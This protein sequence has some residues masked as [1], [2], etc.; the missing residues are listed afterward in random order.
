M[1]SAA[2]VA[3]TW[4]HWLVDSWSNHDVTRGM[5]LAMVRCHVAQ[6]WAATWHPFIGYW[7]WLFIKILWESWG[8]TPGPPHHATPSQSPPDQWATRLFLLC[9]CGQ[10]YLNLNFVYWGGVGPG[11]SPDPWSFVCYI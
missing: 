1:T 11:L 9:I 8:S 6:S 5:F 3:M 2:Y 7:F 4:Q 10:I